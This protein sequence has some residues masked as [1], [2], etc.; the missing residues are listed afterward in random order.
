MPS[1]YSMVLCDV[2]VSVY[3]RGTNAGQ[4]QQCQHT[5]AIV[6]LLRCLFLMDSMDVGA[7]DGDCVIVQTGFAWVFLGYYCSLQDSVM[8]NFCTSSAPIEL[9]QQAQARRSLCRASAS[10]TSTKIA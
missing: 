9:V 7:T 1:L 6:S 8:C 2:S 3:T 5:F 4:P 10:Q